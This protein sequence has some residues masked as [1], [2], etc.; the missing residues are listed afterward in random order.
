MAEPRL[1]H[2]NCGT[3]CPRG[4]RFLMGE[5]GLLEAGRMVCHV[6]L[7]EG[8]DGLVLVDTG[9]GSDDVGDPRRLP[10]PFRGAVRPQLSSSETAQSQIRS[11]GL[12]PEDVR[13]IVVTHLDIDHVGGL[14]DFPQ[15][16]VHLF[17]REHEARQS[18]PLLERPRY[19]SA[20][21]GWAHGPRWVPHDVDGDDWFGFQ[22]VRVL[23]GTSAELLLIPLPGHTLGHT[24]VALR[25]GDGWLLHCGD[26][27]FHR[28]ETLSPPRCPPGLRAFQNIT[29]ADGR[30]RRANRERLSELAARHGDEVELI[31]SHDPVLLERAQAAS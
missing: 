31:C 5:G 13:H 15:A 25:R 20:A 2:L 29:Q 24:G 12:D 22:S 1:H 19:A 16:D 10:L 4:R 27:Y 18:P 9:F 21:H 26:A 14:P 6:L 30:T 7:V 28:D 3:M 17:A 11:L 23:P 8:D